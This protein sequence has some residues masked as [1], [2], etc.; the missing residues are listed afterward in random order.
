[1]LADLLGEEEEE[2]DDVLGLACEAGA[3][4][5]VLRGDADRTGVTCAS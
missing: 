1:V 4:D 2:V 3:E 5:G